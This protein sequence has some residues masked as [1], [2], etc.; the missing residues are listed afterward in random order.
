MVP[1]VKCLLSMMMLYIL[2]SASV[3]A[4]DNSS[5]V[6]NF[7]A[8][9]SDG[10]CGIQLS[11]DTL[12][13]GVYKAIDFQPAKA[14]AMLP[15]TATVTCSG[16]TT[17]KLTVTG[18][19]PYS[20]SPA[21]FRDADSVADG[22]GFMVQRDT[23]S[24]D[25]SSFYNESTAINNGT[26]FSLSPVSAADTPQPEFFLLGLVRAGSGTVSPGVIKAALMFTVSFD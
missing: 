9:I 16:P 3:W 13:F 18:T 4:D 20:A 25:L 26:S 6:V 15:L 7:S 5:V 24:L 14:V 23:G 11:E 22:A 2:A 1:S 8:Q 19:T 10:T 17:P 12:Q 21:I